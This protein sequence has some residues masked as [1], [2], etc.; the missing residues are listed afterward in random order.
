MAAR[1]AGQGGYR[2]G[3]ESQACRV[4]AKPTVMLATGIGCCG[5]QVVLVCTSKGQAVN[6]KTQL[7][8]PLHLSH[9]SPLLQHFF[10]SLPLRLSFS[11]ASHERHI[12]GAAESLSSGGE[13]A[14][15]Q[16]CHDKVQE[17]PGRGEERD[18]S[19]EERWPAVWDTSLT[20][21]LSEMTGEMC[22]S[23]FSTE[24][25]TQEKLNTSFSLHHKP[26]EKYHLLPLSPSLNW[27]CVSS[28]ALLSALFQLH[29]AAYVYS[30]LHQ[31]GA[32]V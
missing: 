27:V 20:I 11:S 10:F 14:C 23:Y 22:P 12:Q 19:A 30:R 24:Q 4:A 31:L 3:A 17:R 9:L 25:M 1:T 18:R 5:P 8:F 26:Q 2:G 16:G 6:M 28:F 21:V 13:T 29:P 7:I 32:H 15:L